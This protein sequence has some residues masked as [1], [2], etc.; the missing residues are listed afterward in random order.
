MDSQ[1]SPDLDRLV[2][3]ALPRR[4]PCPDEN[5]LA[6]I[7][8][9]R[10]DERERTAA[11][12]HIAVCEACRD[13]VRALAPHV[14]AARPA[15]RLLSFPR[16]IAA[17]AAVVLAAAGAAFILARRG[18]QGGDA[19]PAAALEV[20]ASHLSRRVPEEFGDFRP[21]AAEELRAH[22][23]DV[24]RGGDLEASPSGRILDGRPTL[25][26]KA[27][28]GARHYRVSVIGPEGVLWN[29]TTTDTSLPWPEGKPELAPNARAAWTVTAAGPGATEVRRAIAVVDD[30]EASR[31][32][33]AELGAGTVEAP[34]RWL[35]LAHLAL[36]RD[37]P[38]EAHAYASRYVAERPG[39]ALGAA[40]LAAAAD[41]LS[42]R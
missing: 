18:T 42:A 38:L 26:W 11:L 36:R 9:G 1:R 40:T 22:R 10:L 34:L 14:A 16:K 12:D 17:I 13:L 21:L 25:R 5:V 19:D 4:G 28:P 8:E 31:W 27:V 41:R 30:A 39:E 37:L 3:E 2:S 33:R 23:G 24:L 35:L 7:A 15:G 6:A 29:A 20:A 32:R